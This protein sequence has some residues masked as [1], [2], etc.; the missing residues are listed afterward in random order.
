MSLSQLDKRNPGYIA[1]LPKE[2]VTE[3]VEDYQPQYRGDLSQRGSWGGRGAWGR[4][5][6][7]GRGRG[8]RGRGSRG[9]YQNK[10]NTSLIEDES[11]K[12]PTGQ[13]RFVK[14]L[15]SPGSYAPRGDRGRGYSARGSRGRGRGSRGGHQV[16]A[17]AS[18]SE[19]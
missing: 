2:L 7:G 1:P 6:R 10:E 16:S 19:D 5:E 18:K 17:Y 4:G 14:E 11:F 8:E 12:N 15:P 3:F 9:G 13:Q